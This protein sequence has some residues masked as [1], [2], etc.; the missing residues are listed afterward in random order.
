MAPTDQVILQARIAVDQAVRL[1]EGKP[2]ATGGR[3]QL[4]D[5]GR[6]AEHVQPLP[7][8]VTPQ[9]LQA[10]DTTTTLAPAGWKPIFSIE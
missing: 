5:L 1:I 9:T 7:V 4:T 2:M 8:A 6:L 10:F 3:P